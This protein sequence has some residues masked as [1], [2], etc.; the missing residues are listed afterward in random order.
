MPESPSL[1]SSRLDVSWTGRR[2]LPRKRLPQTLE[3]GSQAAVEHPALE[4][5]DRAAEKLRRHAGLCADALAGLARENLV[6][7]GTVFLGKRLS[8]EHPCAHPPERLIFQPLV[9]R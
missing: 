1:T 4:L 3:P 8:R 6:D 9:L 5:H 2:S 7:A